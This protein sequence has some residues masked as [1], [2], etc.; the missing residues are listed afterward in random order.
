[1]C[2]KC[3]E[4]NDYSKRDLP[5]FKSCLSATEIWSDTFSFSVSA[6][7]SDSLS[8][9][10]V[11]YLVPYDLNSSIR[12]QQGSTPTG[13]AHLTKRKRKE[14]KREGKK[15]SDKV[16]INANGGRVV[17]PADGGVQ[18]FAVWDFW[19]FVRLFFMKSWKQRQTEAVIQSRPTQ[20]RTC[21]SLWEF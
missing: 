10:V 5:Q 8:V 20:S 15:R 19:R 9:F 16:W 12:E 14:K 6:F 18:W 17:S 3:W 13:N 11:V 7:F 21:A 2:L 1:M 4:T